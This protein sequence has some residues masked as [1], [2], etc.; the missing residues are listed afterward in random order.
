MRRRK[1][2][3]RRLDLDLRTGLLDLSYLRDVLGG[4]G[5][6]WDGR[7]ANDGRGFGCGGPR[8]AGRARTSFLAA[9]LD[10]GL[11]LDGA[12]LDDM[13]RL[14]GGPV[15]CAM[16]TAGAG[17]RSY[18]TL[19]DVEGEG[20]GGV[21]DR[22]VLLVLDIRL[23]LDGVNPVYPETVK[24]LYS[25]SGGGLFYLDPHHSRPAVPPVCAQPAF[26]RSASSCCGGSRTTAPRRA[27]N[28][29]T[30]TSSTRP[31]GGALTPVEEAH[32]ARA[33]FAAELHTFHC[34]RGASAPAAYGDDDDCVNAGGAIEIEDDWVAP[35]A[36]PPAP[37][38]KKSSVHYRFPA[39]VEDGAALT[40]SPQSQ[41]E[42]EREGERQRN[43]TVSS[44]SGGES[45][46]RSRA[47]WRTDG[48]RAEAS[49]GAH[50]VLSG[51]RPYVLVDSAFF[52]FLLATTQ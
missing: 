9:E 23:G 12:A 50:R 1:L 28:A 34:E 3:A 20:R 13:R 44:R 4:S 18:L 37:N 40:S 2:Q 38:I 48:R 14:L 17:G 6:R 31:P 33:Y 47:G 49:R 11:D 15:R 7:G 35:V 22:P 29:Q 39:S 26:T 51:A 41:P 10:F 16:R 21:G 52:S 27:H 19:D 42:P 8:G 32:F 24:L 46:Q 45:G 25:R 5:E 30:L 36:P 43:A